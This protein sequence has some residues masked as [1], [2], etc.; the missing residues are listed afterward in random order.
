MTNAYDE[1]LGEVYARNYCVA[2]NDGGEDGDENG[3]ENGE[4][5]MVIAWGSSDFF[6]LDFSGRV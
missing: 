4:L 2:E 1:S 5:V 6:R 3:D